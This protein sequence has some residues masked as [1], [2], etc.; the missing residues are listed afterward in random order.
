MREPE[1]NERDARPH[2]QTEEEIHA[3]AAAERDG[4]INLARDVG[5][6]PITELLFTEE[7]I[8]RIE[9]KA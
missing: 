7:D 8:R 2:G 6:T 9:G 3:D 4:F 1:Y 5:V